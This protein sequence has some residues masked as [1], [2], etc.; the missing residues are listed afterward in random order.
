MIL[1]RPLTRTGQVLFELAAKQKWL[2]IESEYLLSGSSATY[3]EEPGNRLLDVFVS[4]PL[5]TVSCPHIFKVKVHVSDLPVPC[6]LHTRID[7]SFFVLRRQRCFWF[8]KA[9]AKFQYRV[10]RCAWVRVTGDQ[11]RLASNPVS[12]YKTDTQLYAIMKCTFWRISEF[13][14]ICLKMARCWNFKYKCQC[15]WSFHEFFSCVDCVCLFAFLTKMRE[16]AIKAE[17]DKRERDE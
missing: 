5:K 7:K 10:V 2:T 9:T 13:S 1:G 4:A 11:A 14:V 6:L 17:K 15:Q 3:F 16:K 8:A 12:K